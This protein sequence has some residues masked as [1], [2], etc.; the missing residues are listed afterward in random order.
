LRKRVN[1][2]GGERKIKIIQ[3]ESESQSRMTQGY[4]EVKIILHFPKHKYTVGGQ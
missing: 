4:G 3:R 2:G 1:K